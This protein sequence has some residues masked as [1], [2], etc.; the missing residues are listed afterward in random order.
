MRVRYSSVEEGGTKSLTRILRAGEQSGLL[1]SFPMSEISGGRSPARHDLPDDPFQRTGPEITGWPLETPEERSRSLIE[2]AKEKADRTIKD[3]EKRRSDI[4][5]DAYEKAF[6]QGEKAGMEMGKKKA[7]PVIDN[8]YRT[9]EELS[10]LKAKIYQESEN[11]LVILASC[12]ARSILHQE[13]TTNQEVT[14]GIVKAALSNAIGIGGIRIRVSQYDIEFIRQCK[15][16]ILDSI[17]GLTN[18]TLEEDG[19]ILRGGCVVETDFG[20]I[21]ARIESQIA[22]MDRVLRSSL[23]DSG[24]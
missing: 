22:E 13:L 6:A 24:I 16:Q 9:I 19:S 4:E 8:F 1:K 20:D 18:I 12:I 10:A 23:R 21:D 2:E 7:E 5:R 11:E 15:P 3:A 14:I 17:E